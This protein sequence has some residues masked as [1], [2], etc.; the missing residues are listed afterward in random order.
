LN[1]VLEPNTI[2]RLLALGGYKKTQI[3]HDFK[4]RNT[5]EIVEERYNYCVN[6]RKMANVYDIY[7]MNL[8]ELKLH[9]FY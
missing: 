1:V 9:R 5:P 8:S 2:R 7:F 3:L 6:Y 4:K